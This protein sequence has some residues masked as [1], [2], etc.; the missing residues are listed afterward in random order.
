MWIEELLDGFKC[1]ICGGE[2]EVLIN[3]Y[4]TPRKNE[5]GMHDT[6][7]FARLSCVN[8]HGVVQ[9]IESKMYNF[10]EGKEDAV[11]EGI[12]FVYIFFGEYRKENK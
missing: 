4:Y 9:E 11:E 2:A 3:V 1:P 10:A 5:Y 12:D 8:Q 7:C 6:Y